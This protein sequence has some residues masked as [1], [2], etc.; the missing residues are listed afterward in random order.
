MTKIKIGVIGCGTI[1]SVVA[2]KI[3][4]DYK[5]RA[6]LFAI[7]DVNVENA[8][9]LIAKC[10]TPKTQIL[11]VDSLIDSV[12]V[13]VEAAYAESVKGIVS[14][15][16][17]QKKQVLVMS[18][19]GLYGNENLFA[20]AEKN[21][22]VIYIPTGAIAGLDCIKAANKADLESVKLITRKPPQGLI[23]AP[24]IIKNNIDIEN[25]K[26]ETV[27]FQGFAKDAVTAFPK[28]INVAAALS[29]A[30]IGFEKTEV[31]IMTSPTYTKNSHE[32]VAIGSFGT[33]TAKTENVPSPN[34]PKTSYLA[35]LSAVAALDNLLSNVR[36]GT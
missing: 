29:F 20:E 22:A 25:I 12:D 10:G 3:V 11:D 33:L 13:V 31:V 5:Q 9:A 35:V 24:H 34:N 2:E 1:G 30:G 15:V 21:D 19:G 14:K 6:E 7:S 23:G 4:S 27:I 36:V 28:N 26:E 18:V 8:E 32:I 17:S 16:I